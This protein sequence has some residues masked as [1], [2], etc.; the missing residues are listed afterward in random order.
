MRNK[1]IGVIW[2][3]SFYG[4]SNSEI[5]YAKQVNINDDVK[6]PSLIFNE[7]HEFKKIKPYM[8]KTRKSKKVLSKKV[9]SLP[10]IAIEQGYFI[11][12][13]KMPGFYIHLPAGVKIEEK[14]KDFIFKK[15]CATAAV[16]DDQNSLQLIQE[17]PNLRRVRVKDVL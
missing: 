2:M 7:N 11:S 8:S 15:G 5:K 9:S 4:G 3:A 10:P 16:F 13:L 6:Q 12:S 1:K 14:Q 17:R